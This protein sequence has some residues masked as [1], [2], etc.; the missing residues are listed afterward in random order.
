VNII[1]VDDEAQ[2][3]R[4]LEILLAQ[5]ELPISLIAS[6]SNGKEA[7][8]I[9]RKQEIDIVVTDI[10]MPVMDGIALIRS[11]KEERSSVQCLILSS[12]GE[13]HYASEAIK[14][15]AT[16]YMLKA[17]ITAAD[18]RSALLK[19]QDAIE[20][21]RLRDQEVFSLK[22]T[23]HGNQYALR[24]LFFSELLRGSGVSVQDFESKMQT[25][26]IPLQSKHT[27]VMVIRSDGHGNV[28]EN[29]KISE[30][31][32]LDSAVI[33]IIDE[34]LQTETNSGSCF[35][36]EQVY[37]VAVYNY[38][39][40]S[41]K[42]LRETTLHHAHRIAS[43]LQELL[44]LSVS[45][46][47]S[48]PA[49]HI[50]SLAK[51]FEEGQEVLHHKQFYGKRSISWYSDEQTSVISESKNPQA[52]IEHLSELLDRK[53]YE[54]VL[55]YLR[56]VLED[57][58]LG[59]SWSEKEVRAFAVE[60]VFLLQRTLRRLKA[61]AG[62]AS[63]SQEAEMPH[64]VIGSLPT[65]DHVKVWLL[66]RAVHDL[67]EVDVWLHPYS[68]AIRSVCV[69]VKANYVEGVSLLEAADY[70]HLNRN[71]L[72][73]LFKK[74]TGNSFND[75][76]TQVRIEKVKELIVDGKT[77]IGLLSEKVG[78]PDGSYLSKVFKKVTGMTPLEFKRKKG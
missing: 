15:G 52:F 26:H 54:T 9:C 75:Y 4:W 33:N 11:L 69:Y 43:H 67:G 8:D 17:E 57:I 20:K 23:I 60:A 44:G 49:L 36:F 76:L 74:E 66:D 51:Q 27:M 59:M 24:S 40:W 22:R 35:I 37:Y 61:A 31:E 41:E 30:P 10:K 46:G 64:E 32:L 39:Q 73:E 5:T 19:V 34:T 77:P 7:L 6:C 68:D 25:L 21:Q 38:S 2:I 53:R 71:Y 63:H 12:Y 70:V 42:S 28:K 58:E 13:F 50:V 18:L 62:I 1:L 3:R 29:V 16:D 56:G 65:F 14:A 55:P 48:M 45:I 72:S 47:I 78:Y